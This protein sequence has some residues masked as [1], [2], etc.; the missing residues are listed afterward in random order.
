MLLL[1]LQHTFAMFGAH[2]LV[3]IITGVSVSTTCIMA[4]WAPCL[5][6]LTKGKV[7][8]ILVPSFS[9]F[10]G[11]CRCCPHVANV[12]PTPEMLP[13]ACGGD[14]EPGYFNAVLSALFKGFGPKRTCATFRRCHAP[15][16]SASGLNLSPV[17]GG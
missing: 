1:G 8:F 15:S 12:R 2:V 17:C 11:V 3:P 9:R 10:C 16:S 14:F 13:Y 4:V 7:L 5:F 6:T